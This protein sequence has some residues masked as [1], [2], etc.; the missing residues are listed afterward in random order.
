MPTQTP[1]TKPFLK[2]STPS[3]D[4][5]VTFQP[6][7]RSLFVVATPPHHAVFRELIAQLDLPGPPHQPKYAKVYSL[8][9][10]DGDVASSALNTLFQ[11]TGAQVRF[12]TAGNALVVIAT[13]NQHKAVEQSLQQMQG[14][15]REL[16]VFTLQKHRSARCRERGLRTFSLTHPKGAAP[17]VS[18]D[19]DAQRLFVR[20]T[21]PQIDQIRKLLVSLGEAVTDAAGTRQSGDVRTIPFR[22]DTREAVRQIEAIWARLRPNR[23]QVITPSERNELPQQLRKTEG[24]PS[25]QRAKSPDDIDH[26]GNKSS[27]VRRTAPLSFRRHAA[28]HAK[29]RT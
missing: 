19:Y 24:E 25:K 26:D 21:K 8:A 15:E 4:V 6:A 16:E 13:D 12:N 9:N 14:I 3:S 5:S 27:A 1:S 17:S 18:S 2:R 11:G 23:I 7:T 28:N 29:A 20:G 22:G 10:I